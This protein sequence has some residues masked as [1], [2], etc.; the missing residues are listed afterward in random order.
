MGSLSQMIGLIPGAD[1]ILRSREINEKPIKKA[2]AIILS[3]T[4]EERE[5][6]ELLNGS[7][8]KRIA[9]GSGTTIQ[10]VNRLVKQFYEM[11]K[12]IKQVSRGKFSNIFRNIQLN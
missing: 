10:E 1:R 8:R 6:P 4:E 9:A 5:N 3:M 7:R 12:M 11:R 2:E